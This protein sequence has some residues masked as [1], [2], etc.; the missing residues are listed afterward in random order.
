MNVVS[1]N[2][3]RASGNRRDAS[4]GAGSIRARDVVSGDANAI[5]V[6][7]EERGISAAQSE[8]RENPIAAAE[9]DSIREARADYYGTVGIGEQRHGL[10]GSA[11]V[12]DQQSAAGV[13]AWRGKIGR[14]RWS[15]CIVMLKTIL[16]SVCGWQRFNVNDVAGP[17][18]VHGVG[19]CLPW[20]SV[21]AGIA[22]AAVRGDKADA[23]G[24]NREGNG[25]AGEAIC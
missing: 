25:V 10:G 17:D 16:K 7:H 6:A 14:D 1:E 20:L 2:G 3:N 11:T 5:Y 18:G 12:T 22:V 24:A 4:R 8:S 13:Y 9:V 21:G 23:S 19:N 15:Q